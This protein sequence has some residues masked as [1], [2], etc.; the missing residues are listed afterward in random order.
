[1]GFIIKTPIENKNIVFAESGL[2][3]TQPFYVRY[4]PTP[5]MR[6]IN[7]LFEFNYFLSLELENRFKDFNL[8]ELTEV[9]K[10]ELDEDGNPTGG[11][12]IIKSERVCQ[13]KVMWNSASSATLVFNTMANQTFEQIKDVPQ[14]KAMIDVLG[15][16]S[17]KFFIA[18]HFAGK[19]ILEEQ[20]GVGNVEIDFTI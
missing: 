1:M 7:A 20:F 9:E 11:T 19:A 13:K 12:V 18:T 4:T 8:K 17:V 3:I 14:V 15:D 2:P 5:Q 16:I 10:P 6:G